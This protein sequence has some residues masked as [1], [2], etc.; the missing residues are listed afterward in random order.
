MKFTYLG[1][2]FIIV[3]LCLEMWQLIR[4][5]KII[6]ERIK[7]GKQQIVKQVQGHL[8]GIVFLYVKQ[9]L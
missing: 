4:F 8:L 9:Y 7:M 2:A 1:F 6:M 5:W 3:L